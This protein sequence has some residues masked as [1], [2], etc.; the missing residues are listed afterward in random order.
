MKVRKSGELIMFNP[1]ATLHHDESKSR[2]FENTPEKQERF[3]RE[4]GVFPVQ[5]GE[6]AGG[7]RSV[8]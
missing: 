6:R 2:G 1:Y 8:L 3:N 5:V 7:R 4:N